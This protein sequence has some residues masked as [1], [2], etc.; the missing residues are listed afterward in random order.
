ML[1]ILQ[2][3]AVVWWIF[4]LSRCSS[5]Y[6][7]QDTIHTLKEDNL[8]LQHRLENLTR[9]LKELKHLLTET[10]KASQGEFD[11][12]Y[13][14]AWREWSQH[15]I[16]AETHQMLEQALCLTELHDAAHPFFISSGLL[17]FLTSVVS[18][19]AAHFWF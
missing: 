15:G 17:L 16:S 5:A 2:I 6:E 12:A 11:P 7:L 8:H 13:V 10:S 4:L 9:A 14:H 1:P 18:V 19:L 3:T